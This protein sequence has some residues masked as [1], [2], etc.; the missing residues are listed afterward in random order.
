MLKRGS[1]FREGRTSI[2]TNGGR[3]ASQG[4]GKGFHGQAAL[5]R[6]LGCLRAT[7]HVR[8]TGCCHGLQFEP[9]DHKQWGGGWSWC[10]TCST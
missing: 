7:I 2:L 8:H 4:S 10:I 5:A 9:S 3:D 1:S 6:R